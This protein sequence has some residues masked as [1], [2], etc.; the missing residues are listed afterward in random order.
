MHYVG[1]NKDC[2]FLIKRN[3]SWYKLPIVKKFS[4][5]QGLLLVGNFL[6]EISFYVS[7]SN[8]LQN[9]E[10][11]MGLISFVCG[12]GSKGLSH[13]LGSNLVKVCVIKE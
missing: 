8:F 9:S 3:V 4:F 12:L 5:F 11:Y 2:A 1:F 13:V 6:S 10:G 7:G